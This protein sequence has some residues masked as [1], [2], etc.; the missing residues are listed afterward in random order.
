ML[1]RTLSLAGILLVSALAAAADWPQWQGPER[2]NVSKENGLLK[3]WPPSG[4][5]L[6]W[7]ATLKT[8]I[9]YSGPAVV[10]DRMYILGANDSNDFAIALDTNTGKPVWAQPIGPLVKNSYG[11][12]PRST[13][14]VDGEHVYVLSASGRLSCLKTADGS[15][16]W[17]VELVGNLGGAKPNWNYSESPLVDGEQVICT[18]G[19]AK[20]AMAALNK[21][22]GEVL[23]R[24]K[25]LKDAAGYSS[26]VLDQT[27]GIRQYVQQTMKGVAGVSAKDGSLLWY[28]ANPAFRVAIIPTPIIHDNFVYVTDGYNIGCSLLELTPEGGKFKVQQVYD[29]DARKVVENKH[30]AVVRVGDHVYGWTDKGAKWVCQEFKTGNEVWSSKSLGR[31]SITCAD[32]SL[33]CYSEDKGTCVLVPASPVG[34]SEKGRFTIPRYTTRREFKNNIWAHPV[35]ANGRLYLRDQE[36]IFCYDLKQTP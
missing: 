14:T 21:N 20:G 13:P 6:L 16:V 15:Q 23:W 28:F 8:G 22:T 5:K 24:C 29:D 30:E 1:K 27:G 10:G 33:Y 4:P 17:A 2:D 7:T 31:G 26:V 9:G 25:D 35:V 19:G 3:A 12:G 18:P 32:G 36:L 34:W 11:S